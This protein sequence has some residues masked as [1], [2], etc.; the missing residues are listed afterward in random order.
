MPATASEAQCS[1]QQVQFLKQKMAQNVMTGLSKASFACLHSIA[2][3][4]EIARDRC[5]NQRDFFGAILATNRLS[6]HT[7]HT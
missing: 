1:F 5:V 4:R 7:L 3:E 6:G 2:W